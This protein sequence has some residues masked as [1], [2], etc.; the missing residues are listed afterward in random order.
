M[1]GDELRQFIQRASFEKRTIRQLE[2][3]LPDDS[4]LDRL[5]EQLASEY[6][7]NE[8]RIPCHRRTRCRPKH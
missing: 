6:A 2:S 7:G 3:M 1:S 4:E 5:L 8:F